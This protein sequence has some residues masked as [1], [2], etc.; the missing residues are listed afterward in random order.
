[1]KKYL[2]LISILTLST[3]AHAETKAV[4]MISIPLEAHAMVNLKSENC[5]YFGEVVAKKGGVFEMV[6]KN[7]TCGQSMTGVDLKIS[8]KEPLLKGSEVTIAD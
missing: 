3:M 6:L 1:M 2:I 7:K 8:L 5:F 4:A